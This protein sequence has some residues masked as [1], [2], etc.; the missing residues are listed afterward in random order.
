MSSA[1]GAAE[2]ILPVQPTQ[3][4]EEQKTLQSRASQPL[5]D[6]FVEVVA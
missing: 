1:G 4:E 3:V 2:E 5:A 6:E